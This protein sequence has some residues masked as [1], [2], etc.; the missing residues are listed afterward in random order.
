MIKASIL[1]VG[2]ELTQGQITNQNATWISDRLT[3]LGYDVK[4]HSAVPDDRE[5]IITQLDFLAVR[6]DLIVVT[7]GLGPTSDD[8]TRDVLATWLGT[9]LVFVEKSW[10]KIVQRLTERGIEVAESN[11]SQCYFPEGAKV[12]ENQEGTADGFS[13]RHGVGSAKQ[14]EVL[15]LPGPP[16]E[17]MHLWDR[18]AA[19]WL[20]ERFGAQIP[21]EMESWSCLGKSESSLG[22]IVEATVAGFG[23]QTGYRATVPYVEVKVWI[24]S[25]YPREKRLML[26]A[27]LN[28]ELAPYSVTRN[29]EDL[30]E[31]LLDI[32]ATK[33]GNLGITI[34]DL[35]TEGILTERM[36][37][38]LKTERGRAL[39]SR[40]ELLTRYAPS[41][42]AEELPE[43][44][45]E[46]ILALFPDGEVAA[47]GPKGRTII[48][49]PTPYAAPSMIERL[50]RYRTELALQA[51]TRYFNQA[52]QSH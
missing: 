19:A 10:E 14:T 26:L 41:A 8:F 52:D 13:F 21:D 38:L 16:R 1:A 31:K 9:P 23:V 6:T 43:S 42:S 3:R 35:G 15:V 46:W 44:A 37:Q 2:T 5:G 40:V 34:L 48:S 25:G 17:G 18:F 36:L 24:P 27:K 28:A 20:R 47:I 12:L 22:E 51:W 45:S 49:L 7:G 33:T 29:G 32:L 4:V 30:G 11:R 50:R 39:Q